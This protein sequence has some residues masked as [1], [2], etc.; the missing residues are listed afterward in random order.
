[1]SIKSILADHELELSVF[2]SDIGTCAAPDCDWRKGSMRNGEVAAA[3]RAHLA[4][5]IRAALTGDEAVEVVARAIFA[6]HEPALYAQE[7][8]GTKLWR[9]VMDQSR[10]ASNAALDAL[11]GTVLGGD[12]GE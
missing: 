5:L 6:E 10:E 12:R 1:M 11:V 8:R 3:H 9:A 7:D 4:D 2:I